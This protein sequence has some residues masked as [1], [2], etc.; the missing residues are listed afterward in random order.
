V[1]DREVK[2]ARK[3]LK[4]IKSKLLIS[5]LFIS[6]IGGCGFHTPYK[7]KSINA[8]ITGQTQSI[9]AKKITQRLNRDI[10]ST[11]TVEII[12]ET[13]R[14][15]AGSYNSNGTESGYNLTYSAPIK[16]YDKDQKLLLDKSFSANTYLRK[17][18]SSQA[19]RIQ[20]EEAYEKLSDSIV[21]KFIRQLNRLN[22]S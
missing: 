21:R 8:T 9:L 10:P 2:I 4:M 13:K 5:L 18:T 1:V 17:L 16:V 6:I 14:Q 7:N 11:L 15:D 3:N 12:S 22:E 20:I 19:D